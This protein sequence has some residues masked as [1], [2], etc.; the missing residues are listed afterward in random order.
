MPYLYLLKYSERKKY[1]KLLDAPW[2]D[3]VQKAE[4]DENRKTASGA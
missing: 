2:K 1:M 3:M 4:Y